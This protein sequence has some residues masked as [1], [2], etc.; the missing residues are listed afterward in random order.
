MIQYDL[1]ESGYV[2]IAIFNEKGQLIENLIDSQQEAGQYTISWDGPNVTSGL[3]FI[4]IQAGNFEITRKCL[5][6]K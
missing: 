1:P 6:L 3:Y 2:T 5:L 4:R